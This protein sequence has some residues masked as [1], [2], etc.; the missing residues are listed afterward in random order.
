M[1]RFFAI[2][3]LVIAAAVG[4]MVYSRPAPKLP[5]RKH[6]PWLLQT[7]DPRELM[8]EPTSGS[9]DERALG[10]LYGTYIG[11][12]YIGARIGPEGVGFF[13]GAPLPCLM[14][15]LWEGEGLKALPNW[16]DLPIYDEK[17]KRFE[18]DWKAPYRQTLNMRDGYVQTELTLKSGRQRLEGKIT[19]FITRMGDQSAEIAAIRCEFEPK[20][21]RSV[22]LGDAIQAQTDWKQSPESNPGA[23]IFVGNTAH[24]ETVAIAAVVDEASGKSLRV[25][26]DKPLVLTK[27]VAIV[28]P[29][30]DN[31]VPG[32]STGQLAQ[33]RLDSVR[34]MGYDNL[35]AAHKRAWRDVWKSDIVIEGAPEDQ[36]AVHSMMFY[37][38]CSANPEHSIAPN[39]LSGGAWQGHIFWDADLWMF[40]ALILQHP[41]QAQGIVNYRLRTM[42]GAAENARKRGL[43]GIE[44]AWEIARTGRESAPSPYTEER[45]VTADASMA[46][47]SVYDI[48]PQNERSV[49]DQM[50]MSTAEYWASRVT[51]NK[52]QDRYEILNVV[53]PDEDAQIV[54]NSVYTNAAARRNIELA[55]RSAKR[56]GAGYPSEWDD[57]VKKMY[58]P[59]DEKSRRFIEHD[60][61]KRDKIKQADTELLIYPL[62][63]P[64]S[65]DVKRNTFDFYKTKTDPRGPAMTSSIH[66]I[67]AAELGRPEEAL[68]HFD[69]S[70]KPFMRGPLLMFNEKRSLTYDNMYFVTGSG[71]ALQSVIYGFG[72]LR[73]HHAPSGFEEALPGLYIKPCL[74]PKWT[75]LRI[76]GIRWQGNSYDLTVLPGNKWEMSRSTDD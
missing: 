36:Q 11:N 61:F 75:K 26:R 4:F 45:H 65:E 33:S 1:K 32:Y 17:G 66:A 31:V 47:A 59:F 25:Q 30:G 53:P 46:A 15:G 52:V 20:G 18:L 10:S 64:M 67:I 76:T 54:N 62:A 29:A 70:W 69:D 5:V 21:V 9:D 51:Y 24:G 27:Y 50:L 58:I 12:G 41:E 56:R 38:L 37:L 13:G 44:F 14:S 74:P 43:K 7:N 57:I 2:G 19:F 3:I 6:D 71:G 73:M 34:K 23:G 16:S 49:V 60:G 28:G 39:G 68:K 72:G 8:S 22:R 55:I 63:M 42:D 40:P 35:F 48:L